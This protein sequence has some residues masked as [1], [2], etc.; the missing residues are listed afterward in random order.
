MSEFHISVIVPIYNCCAY[1]EKCLASIAA[2]TMTNFEVILIDDGSSDGSSEIAQKFAQENPGWQYIWQ[3][4]GGVAVARNQGLARATGEYIAFI[5]A[6]DHIDKCMLQEM[7]IAAQTEQAD[8]VLCNYCE[9]K[10]G[11]CSKPILTF[12]KEI[13]E[14][15]NLKVNLKPCTTEEF[16]RP[17]K[18]PKY[19]VMENEKICRNWQAALHDYL[20][21]REV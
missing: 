18:R 21:L 4:N 5:D 13:F 11:V 9:E 19:S 14:Q 20:E 8:M 15:S 6:D 16:P 10:D 2:Q 12:A 1:L 17:A 3:A 7:Y